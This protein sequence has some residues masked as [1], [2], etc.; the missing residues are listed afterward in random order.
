MQ[1]LRNT[2]IYK[3]QF[4]KTKYILIE[5]KKGKEVLALVNNSD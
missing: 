5:V 3:N 1:H 2:I 4:K